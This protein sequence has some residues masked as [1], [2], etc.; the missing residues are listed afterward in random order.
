MNNKI[1]IV[2]VT[3]VLDLGGGQRYI[4]NLAN[5]W[6]E[7]G[8]N[9]TIIILRSERE[10]FYKISDK[11]KIIKLDYSFTNK[12]NKAINGIKTM[13][14]LRKKIRQI[15]PH[16]VLS[17][18]STTNILTIISTT[19]LKTKVIVR[20]AFSQERKRNKFDKIG[21]K[22]FYGKANGIIAQTKEIKD[23]TE[24]EIGY[25]NIKVIPNPVREIKQNE[26]IKKEKIILNV[27]RLHSNKGQKFFIEA[28][29]K[30]NA[31][32][33]KFVILGE[34]DLRKTLE[35]QIRDLN[36]QHKIE[37][38]GAVKNIDDWLL[39]SSIFVFPSILEG[40]PNA[41]IEAMTAGLPCVS[42]D[43]ETGPRDLIKDGENGFLVPLNNSKKLEARIEELIH[44]PELREIFS[45]EAIKTTKK[46]KV[47]YIAEEVLDFCLNV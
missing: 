41:L 3:P 21:R 29:S 35:Q 15:Q 4:T 1:N 30:I 36:I 31:P 18:L 23:F 16:F 44:N 39:K 13:F 14:I 20:D 24:K 22:I 34:G 11:V 5:Y 8:H 17:I 19:F 10:I 9:V 46:L 32:D 27:G 43:C 38:P 42:F 28:C 6:A 33:W 26:K 2:L 12:A 25:A 47:E 45:Q 40:L 37:M 7:T